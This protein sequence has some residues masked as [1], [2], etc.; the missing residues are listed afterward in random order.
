[1]FFLQEWDALQTISNYVFSSIFALEAAA[2][3][4][5]F[6]PKARAAYFFRSFFSFFHS[7]VVHICLRW[8]RERDKKSE[9]KAK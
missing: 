3:I 6:G 1:M 8:G 4:A 5:A 2:K 7:F 9:Q